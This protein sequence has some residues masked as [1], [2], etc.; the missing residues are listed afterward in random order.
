MEA[1]L[2]LI[3]VFSAVRK[4]ADDVSTLPL[5]GYRKHLTGRRE[6]VELPRVLDDPSEFIGRIDWVNQ[7]MTSLLLRGNAYGLVTALTPSMAPDQITWVHPDEV[8]VDESTPTPRYYW[9]GHPVDRRM[10]LHVR[11]LLLPGSVVG[12]SPIKAA[13]L[14]V[15]SGIA[16]QAFARDWYKNKARPSATFKHTSK[17]L[18][19][20][21]SDAISDRLFAK[22]RAGRPFVTG[23]DWEY[24]QLTLSAED[25]GFILQSKATATQV[26]AMYGLAPEEI[27]GETGNSMTYSTTELNGIKYVGDT[28]STRL[29]RLEESFSR[30]LMPPKEYALFNLDARLRS[31]LKTR[32]EVYK[33]QREIGFASI[34]EQRELE[35]LAPLPDGQGQDYTPLSTKAPTK[36]SR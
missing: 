36:E 14:M 35:D 11:G 28:L 33:S 21:Q 17:T 31:D 3:P 9:N 19:P 2:S 29:L 10:M 18:T 20:E 6:R 16:A 24:S 22:L 7:C 25:A 27:G 1:S 15:E 13:A 26:A 34:D 23:S 32:T 5:Q 30:F 8:Y 12:L 4:I